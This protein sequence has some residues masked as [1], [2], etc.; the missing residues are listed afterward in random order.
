MKITY[1]LDLVSHW[2]LRAEPAWAELKKRYAGRVRFGWKF[3]LIDP[4]NLVVTAGQEDWWYRRGDAVTGK[5][6]RLSTGWVNPDRD[7]DYTAPLRVAEAARD[8]GHEDDIVRLALMHAAMVEGR[9]IGKMEVALA[10]VV[11][12]TNLP[13]EKLR[14]R[15]EA[16]E[17]MERILASTAEFNAHRI[18]ERPAFILEDEIGDKAVFS[19]LLQIEPLAATIDAM[20]AD[21][22]AYAA[23]AKANGDPPKH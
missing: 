8:L 10:V 2:C 23:F 11:S 17:I 12:A 6:M 15:A 20:L 1:Y 21:T 19:G 4:K 5:P 9:P 7:S 3:A 22:A 18:T 16:P 14:V 13:A